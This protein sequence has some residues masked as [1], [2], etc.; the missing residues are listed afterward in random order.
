M[1]YAVQENRGKR[2]DLSERYGGGGL[3]G[4]KGERE[5]GR[6]RAGEEEEESFTGTIL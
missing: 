4:A 5:R 6:R 3:R 2:G 1:G